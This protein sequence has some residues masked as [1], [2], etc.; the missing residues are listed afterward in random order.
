MMPAGHLSPL[1]SDTRTMAPGCRAKPVAPRLPNA[2]RRRRRTSGSFR[3]GPIAALLLAS[4][5]GACASPDGSYVDP[6]VSAAE[7]IIDTIVVIVAGE[8]PNGRAVCLEPLPADQASNAITPELVEALRAE[9]FT[10]AETGAPVL[11]YQL[12]PLETGTLLRVGFN[13]VLASAFFAG[14]GASGPLVVRRSA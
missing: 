5:L 6:H 4:A 10:V 13:G 9:G 14:P 3:L 2:D 7:P 8:H 1:T 11:R 12:T